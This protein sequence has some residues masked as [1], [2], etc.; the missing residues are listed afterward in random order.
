MAGALPIEVRLAAEPDSYIVKQVFIDARDVAGVDARLLCD[1]AL[2]PLTAVL[3]VAA[4]GAL[5]RSQ[6]K[7][8]ISRRLDEAVPQSGTPVTSRSLGELVQELTQRVP[9]GA[10][11]QRL[12]A[13]LSGVLAHTPSKDERAPRLLQLLRGATHLP[14]TT[15]SDLVQRILAELEALAQPP[16][17]LDGLVQAPLLAK[18]QPGRGIS[19]SASGDDGSRQIFLLAAELARR[20]DQRGAKHGCVLVSSDEIQGAGWQGRILG[21]GWNHEVYEQRGNAGRKRVLHAECHAIADAIRRHGEP[22]AF[23]EFGRATAWIIELRD[24]AAYDDAPPCRKCACLLQSVGVL[25]AVHSTRDGALRE[26]ALPSARPELLAE[27]M[28]AKPLMYA[29]DALG[30]RCQ[31]LE[32]A[33]AVGAQSSGT[34]SSAIGYSSSTQTDGV[35]DE[36]QPERKPKRCRAG[37]DLHRD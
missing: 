4:T 13:A 7:A 8:E 19:G 1:E 16:L 34:S 6:W 9:E 23:R 2:P 29:C 20:G 33:L 30:V 21:E 14:T 37:V 12:S 32:E 10:H 31:R 11:A 36:R 27:A 28:A 35:G 26:L 15:A 25:R 24:E 3:Q 22:V 18:H 5:P 17:M